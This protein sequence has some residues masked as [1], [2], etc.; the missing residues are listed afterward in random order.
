MSLQEQEIEELRAAES[1][2]VADVEDD[3]GPIVDDLEPIMMPP[4]E[5][6]AL[7]DVPMSAPEKALEPIADLGD[8]STDTEEVLA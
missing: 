5:E 4:L 2:T 1:S 3:V 6:I 7:E 8:E